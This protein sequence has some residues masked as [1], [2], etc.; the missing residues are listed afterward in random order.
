M[1]AGMIPKN[2]WVQTE[3]GAGRIIGEACH[4]IDLFYYLTDSQPISVSVEAMQTDHEHLFPTDNL[5]VQLSF[6][7]G[8]LCS[9]L[10]TAVGNT[11]MSKERMELFFDGKSIVM[12]DYKELKGYGLPS[13]F[14]EIVSRADKGHAQLLDTFFTALRAP[15]YVPPISFDRLQK[16]AEM[17]LIIDALACKGGGTQNVV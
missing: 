15:Q 12:D 1:N 6:E 5:S 13:H 3:V 14:N 4:I 8:S 10:Y 17:T 9:L 7:D 2:H 11:K 16:V